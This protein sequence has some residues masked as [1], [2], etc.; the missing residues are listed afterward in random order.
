MFSKVM[1]DF[2][3][4]G[5]PQILGRRLFAMFVLGLRGNFANPIA[6]GRKT[7]KFGA[8]VVVRRLI[9]FL[10]LRFELLLICGKC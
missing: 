1:G 2:G 3:G 5:A 9:T 7:P 10:V 6:S 8:T 4:H